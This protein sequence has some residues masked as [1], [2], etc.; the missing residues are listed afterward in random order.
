MEF[1]G[2]PI[3]PEAAREK[4]PYRSFLVLAELNATLTNPAESNPSAFRGLE[5]NTEG[6]WP[7]RE[8]SVVRQTPAYSCDPH[9]FTRTPVASSRN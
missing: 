1:G 6:S 7:V 3:E 8:K 4:S 2:C 5:Q 9:G